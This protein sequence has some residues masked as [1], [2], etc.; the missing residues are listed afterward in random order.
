MIPSE[1]ID[2]FDELMEMVESVD[3]TIIINKLK[4]YYQQWKE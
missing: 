3:S 2:A 4:E 1:K